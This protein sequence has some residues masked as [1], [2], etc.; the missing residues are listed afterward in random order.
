VAVA[1]ANDGLHFES[2]HGRPDLIRWPTGS[3]SIRIQEYKEY[4]R[5]GV[6]FPYRHVLPRSF[7]PYVPLSD[8]AFQAILAAARDRGLVIRT[9]ELPGPF[10]TAMR[11]YDIVAH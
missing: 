6:T 7:R 2:D 8:E 4:R 9:T 10:G 5:G 3:A 1:I 11:L